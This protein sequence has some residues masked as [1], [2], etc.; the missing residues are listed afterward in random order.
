MNLFTVCPCNSACS[1]T[2]SVCLIDIIFILDSSESAKDV[3]FDKQKEFVTVLSDKVFLLKPT[4]VRRYDIKLAIMQFSSSV[5][6]DHSFAHWRDLQYFKQ[7]VIRMSYIGQGTYTYYAI[8]NATQLFKAEGRK[9]GVKV[10]LLMT[11]GIDHPKSPDVQAISE[12][13]RAFG[14]SFITIGLSG[15]ANEAKLR[16]ISGDSLGK[17]VLILNDPRLVDKIRDQ[18]VSHVL[19]VTSFKKLFYKKF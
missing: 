14:I 1:L 19:A 17:R 3:L 16:L 11:D 15:V 8:S 7:E 12:A 6:I 18:L 10:A 5:K 2:D 9:T 4:K 13:A